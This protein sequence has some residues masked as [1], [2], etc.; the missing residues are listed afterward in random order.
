MV[1]EVEVVVIEIEFV[2]CLVHAIDDQAIY[3]FALVEVK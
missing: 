2:D 3:V 1:E